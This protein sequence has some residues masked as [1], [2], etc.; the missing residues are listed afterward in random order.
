MFFFSWSRSC[1]FYYYYYFWFY[2]LCLVNPQKLVD[3]WERKRVAEEIEKK[4]GTRGARPRRNIWFNI[5]LHDSGKM[6]INLRKRGRHTKGVFKPYFIQK[7]KKTVTISSSSIKLCETP[8][9]IRITV[10]IVTYYHSCWGYNVRTV[11]CY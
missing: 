9:V 10:T 7:T 11:T 3:L 5:H 8:P 4:T 2:D 1:F 6:R